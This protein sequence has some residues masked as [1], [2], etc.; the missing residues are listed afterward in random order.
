MRSALRPSRSG[1]GDGNGRV[2]AA[3]DHHRPPTVLSKRRASQLS[4]V[5][6]NPLGD[7]GHRGVLT[8]IGVLL[9]PERAAYL[10]GATIPALF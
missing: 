10:A 9:K 6:V 1:T 7:A 2:P 4:S 3:S 8:D 5:E